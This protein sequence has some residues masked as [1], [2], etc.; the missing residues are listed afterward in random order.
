MIFRSKVRGG[1]IAVPPDL[2]LP[3][4]TDVI[5]ESESEEALPTSL[6]GLSSMRNGVPVFPRSGESSVPDLRIVNEL[7]DEAL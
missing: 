3:D 4:G 5:V 1:V 6:A 7:R 2:R